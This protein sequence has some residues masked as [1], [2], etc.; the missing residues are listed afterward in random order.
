[1]PRIPLS[2][3]PLTSSVVRVLL[4]VSAISDT[5]DQHDDERHHDGGRKYRLVKDIVD[6]R[7]DRHEDWIEGRGPYPAVRAI[8]LGQHS[9]MM[10]RDERCCR[11]L[12]TGRQPLLGSTHPLPPPRS[13][14][15][16]DLHLSPRSPTALS[17]Q[18][19]RRQSA[20]M[21]QASS[22]NPVIRA[23][24]AMRVSAWS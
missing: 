4:V 22:T 20:L 19:S 3:P 14:T 12:W 6:D 21:T 17:R 15:L 5:R 24:S 16:V 9:K 18:A 10:P 1:M 11:A 8:P 2:H 13:P 7:H 23:S